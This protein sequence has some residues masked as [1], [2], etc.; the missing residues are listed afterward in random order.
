MIKDWPGWKNWLALWG[1]YMIAGFV[2]KFVMY[3]YTVEWP[4]IVVIAAVHSGI[5]LAKWSYD[6]GHWRFR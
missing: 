6:K 3:K 2:F 5:Y 4:Y 1:V